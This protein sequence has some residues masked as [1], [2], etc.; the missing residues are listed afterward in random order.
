MILGPIKIRTVGIPSAV[1]QDWWHLYT[2]GSIPCPVQGLKDPVLPQ[3]WCTL[4]LWLRFDSYPG[5]AYATGQLK[6]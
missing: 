1:Q 4:Q 3:L 2:I 6:K 5:I